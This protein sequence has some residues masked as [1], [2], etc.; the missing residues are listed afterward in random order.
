MQKLKIGILGTSNHYLKRIVLPLKETEHCESYAIGSRNIDKAASMARE[1]DIPLWFNSYDAILENAD[2]DMVYIPL[3]NHR[4]KEWVEKAIEAGKP[5]LCEKPIGMDTDEARQMAQ[6]A[7][8]A[9]VPLM[10]GFMYMFHPMWQHARDIVRT[11]QIGHIQYIHTAFSYNNPSP[12]NIRNIP[13]YGGGALMD[14]GCYAI[15]VPRFIMGAE[16][17]RVMSLE[18]KHPEFGTDMHT[19]AILDF[20]GPR[21]T[22]SVSTASQAF[23]KVDIIGSSGSITIHI[24]FNTYVD[25]PSKI[26]VTDG[27]GTRDVEFPVSNAY[28]MMFDAFAKAVKKQMPVPVP[29]ADAVN[30]MKVIDAVRKSAENDGWVV[31]D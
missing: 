2:V 4:H 18:T 25:V 31:L 26:T 16:P 19:S 24:P 10:E 11:R 8:D 27:V 29:L 30:N 3:P 6:M 22:F 1:F 21:A 12:S 23:Q 7:Q 14:I 28:G 15:S 5:V 13:E 9:D 17:K 20:G